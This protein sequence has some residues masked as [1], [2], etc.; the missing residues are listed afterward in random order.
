[1]VVNEAQTLVRLSDFYDEKSM[2]KLNE[3]SNGAY[4]ESEHGH[5]RFQEC[6]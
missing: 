3:E 6:N 2:I 5:G 1:M 4:E